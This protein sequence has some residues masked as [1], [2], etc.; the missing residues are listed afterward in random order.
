M[1]NIQNHSDRSFAEWL[2]TEI[3][4]TQAQID[5]IEMFGG[6]AQEEQRLKNYLAE[7]NDTNRNTPNQNQPDQILL[8]NGE[9]ITASE[10]GGWGRLHYVSY[11]VGSRKQQQNF[12]LCTICMKRIVKGEEHYRRSYYEDKHDNRSG[13]QVRLCLGCFETHESDNPPD[14]LFPVYRSPRQKAA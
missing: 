13:R 14:T 8:E 3:A 4:D 10:N 1:K 7:L 11:A 2:N 6:D 5:D 9:P 12:W